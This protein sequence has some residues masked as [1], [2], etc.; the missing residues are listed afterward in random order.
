MLPKP[1][2][3]EFI[4]EN[5]RYLLVEWTRGGERRLKSDYA[6]AIAPAPREIEAIDGA[7]L[8]A[9]AVARECLREAPA[10]FWR[11]ALPA[12]A[13]NGTPTRVV[14]FEQVPR[15]LWERFRG[16]V[17]AFLALIFPLVPAEPD[18][19]SPARAPDAVELAA[20]AAVS[21]GFRGRAE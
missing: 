10:V 16:E 11:E 15:A 8:Y 1:I 18:R 4:I 19:A 12:G 20:P 17:D 14:T 3:Y 2:E 13:V 6:L 9:E 5:E 21:P 7:N